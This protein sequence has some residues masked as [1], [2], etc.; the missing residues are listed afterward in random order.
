MPCIPRDRDITILYPVGIAT[1]DTHRALENSEDKLTLLET[2]TQSR[3][4]RQVLEC[5]S[6]SD[7]L[8]TKGCGQLGDDCTNYHC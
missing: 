1:I 7:R 5:R 6:N 2:A 4:P 8:V 3:A